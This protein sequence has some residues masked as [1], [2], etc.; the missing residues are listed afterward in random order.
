M[1]SQKMMVIG[2]AVIGIIIG[3]MQTGQAEEKEVVAKIGARVI[4]KAE[5]EQLLNKRGQG[6][7]KDK[8]ME[9]G[10]LNNMAQTMALG[11]AAR[12]KGIDKRKEIE[13]I[14][15]LTIDGLLANEL[16]KEEVIDKVTLTEE[17]AKKYYENHPDQFKIPEKARFRHIMIKVE[18][19]ATDESRRKARE[20]AEEVLIKVKSGEDF[21]KLAMEYSDDPASKAKGGDLGFFEKGRM[22][23]VFDEAA[24]KLNPGEFSGIVETAYGFHIIK[25]E[26]KKK[27]EIEPFETIKD[28]VMTKAKEEIKNEKIK[29]YL[30]QVMKEV[31]VKIFPEVLEKK[32]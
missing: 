27:E 24:F 5:F 16:I 15:E 18:K 2:F 7:S 1:I 20:R 4:T 3:T 14:L 12:K 6:F 28:K 11:D 22:F 26:E 31:D 17:E 19:T 8:Q 29:V 9:I 13:T 10:L 23:K 21:A 30:T 32:E 25:M